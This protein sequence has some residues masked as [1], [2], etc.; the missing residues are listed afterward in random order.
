MD[1]DVGSVACIGGCL[2]DFVVS[3]D[4]AQDGSDND[5]DDDDQG[6]DDD[7]S[8]DWELLFNLHG[9]VLED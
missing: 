3:T 5:C 2:R 4:S 7:D 9:K 6:K 1:S 8:H